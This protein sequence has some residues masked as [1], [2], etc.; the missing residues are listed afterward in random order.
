MKQRGPDF[1]ELFSLLSRLMAA[2]GVLACAAF[3]FTRTDFGKKIIPAVTN[4]EASSLFE[5]V[6]SVFATLMSLTFVAFWMRTLKKNPIP[7]KV[8]LLG[9]PKAGKTVYLTMLFRQLAAYKAAEV[10]FQPYGLETIETVLKNVQTLSGGYWLKPTS[11]DSVFFFRTNAVVGKPKSFFKRYYTVEIGDYAGE[12]MAEFDSTSDRWLHRSEY[13]KYAIGCDALFLAVD[14][15]IL[16]SK[17]N[18]DIEEMQLKLIAALQ[19]LIEE[20]HVRPDSK[21]RVPVGLLI[22]KSDLLFDQSPVEGTI[23]EQEKY[24]RNKL[25][26]LITICQERCQHFKLFFVAAVGYKKSENNLPPSELEPQYVITPMA[27]ALTQFRQ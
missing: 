10:S 23:S 13:F 19:V 1:E 21:M 25:D 2:L 16:A 22:L 14:G 26:R 11:E 12:K 6:I 3:F 20:K 7:R 24:I 27:W 8:A 17:K 15:A 18:Q 5:V 9:A 4:T